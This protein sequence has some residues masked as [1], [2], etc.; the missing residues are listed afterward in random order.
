MWECMCG[1]AKRDLHEAGV[2]GRLH[3]GQAMAKVV[4]Q[5][6]DS[7][8]SVSFFDWVIQGCSCTT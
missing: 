8:G 2:A 6:T 7:L 5:M 4:P 1:T 3:G